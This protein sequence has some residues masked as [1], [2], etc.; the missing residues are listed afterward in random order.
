MPDEIDPEN[1][2]PAEPAKKE[3]D[4]LIV[5][6]KVR[7]IIRAKEKRV[8]DEFIT[9]LSEHVRDTIERAV[10]RA[11]ANGRSTLRDADI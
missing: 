9:A 3:R 1:P 2:T 5:Q 11:T 6:N 4:L 8:S 7:E 10:A